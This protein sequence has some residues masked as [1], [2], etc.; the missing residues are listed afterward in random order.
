M[1]LRGH[2]GP[3]GSDPRR[4]LLVAADR[5]FRRHRKPT[6]HQV[7]AGRYA[8]VAGVRTHR[9]HGGDTNS[10]LTKMKDRRKHLVH[11]RLYPHAALAAA[12]LCIGTIGCPTGKSLALS[13]NRNTRRHDQYG[14]ERTRSEA[15]RY[16]RRV[17]GLALPVDKWCSAIEMSQIP[18]RDDKMYYWADVAQ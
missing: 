6:Q 1:V 9:D 13:R 7:A 16:L 8:G 17:S 18:M 2:S 11:K 3:P 4:P 5:Q 10:L 15:R 12:L 14:T